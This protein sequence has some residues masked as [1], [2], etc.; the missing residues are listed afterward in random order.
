LSWIVLDRSADFGETILLAELQTEYHRVQI[1]LLC[2][3]YLMPSGL[4]GTQIQ[5][6]YL[7]SMA[8]S[9]RGITDAFAVEKITRLY[10]KSVENNLWDKLYF[11]HSF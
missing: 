7:Q 2:L 1:F 10:N 9:F 3:T 6:F 8:T 5:V 4:L 11:E